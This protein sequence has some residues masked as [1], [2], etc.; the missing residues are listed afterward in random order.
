[1]PFTN[2]NN[3]KPEN[4]T[5]IEKTR[6]QFYLENDYNKER[7][8]DEGSSSKFAIWA[9]IGI[10]KTQS[11]YSSQSSWLSNGVSIPTAG[12]SPVLLPWTVIPLVA[13]P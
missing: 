6:S 8:D 10:L 11:Y 5:P 7:E 1:L 2:P 4:Q 13:I 12:F 3:N 9:A